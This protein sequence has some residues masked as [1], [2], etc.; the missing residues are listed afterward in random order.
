[1]RTARLIIGIAFFLLAMFCS[2]QAA[3]LHLEASKY[4]NPNSAVVG[5]LSESARN[6][7]LGA[8]AATVAGLICVMVKAK[9]K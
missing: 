7:G 6:W 8:T 3:R 4:S 9:G 2:V 5:Q 1:M